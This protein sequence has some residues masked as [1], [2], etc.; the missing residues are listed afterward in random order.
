M[1]RARLALASIA[2]LILS[3]GLPLVRAQEVQLAAAPASLPVAATRPNV[4]FA[5]ERPGLQVPK[6]QLT[7]HDD[8]SAIYEGAEVEPSSE[9]GTAAASTRHPFRS[10]VSISPDTSARI[11]ALARKLDLFRTTCASK[12]KNIADTGT[13]I[14]TYTG[15]DGSGSCTYNYTENKDVQA[16]T[17]TFQGIAETMDLGRKLDH[18]RRYDRLGLDSLM[19]SLAQ[20]V[21]DG[22]A[23]ELGTIAASLRSIA[24]D[25]ELME[26]VRMRANKLL[27]LVPADKQPR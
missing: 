10:L 12:A 23:L 4:A 20:E 6:F 5:F 16:L 17:E 14:L 3:T 1:I 26:R 7:I 18:L 27:S 19:S 2:L 25:P 11:F 24:A 21:S 8:G 13:K 22:H 9:H 15:P